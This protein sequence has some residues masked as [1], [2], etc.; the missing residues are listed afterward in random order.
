MGLYTS[1]CPPT[2]S[3]AI[4]FKLENCIDLDAYCSCRTQRLVISRSQSG[5][6]KGKGIRGK[7]LYIEISG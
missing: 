5:L 3:L 2:L 4:K 1:L 6:D 7:E